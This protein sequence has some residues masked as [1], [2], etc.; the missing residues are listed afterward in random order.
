MN[1]GKN[2]L[3]DSGLEALSVS[4]KRNGGLRTLGLHLSEKVTTEGL[5]QF[6]VNLQENNHRTKLTVWCTAGGPEAVCHEMEVVNQ[7]RQQISLARL[8]DWKS[9]AGST[10]KLTPFIMHVY[11]K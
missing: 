5:K 3:T 1:I 6:V 2:E 7:R 9:Q 10:H 11:K 8:E 4:L